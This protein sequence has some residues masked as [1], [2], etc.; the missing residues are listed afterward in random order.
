[1]YQK[2]YLSKAFLIFFIGLSQLL[3]AGRADTTST[4]LD[5]MTLSDSLEVEFLHTALRAIST[6]L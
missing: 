4:H 1:M 2:P 5:V 6:A 3:Y